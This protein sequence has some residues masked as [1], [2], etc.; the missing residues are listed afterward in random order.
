MFEPGGPN[1]SPQR[2]SGQAQVA[3]CRA[4][5]LDPKYFTRWKG[6]L[7]EAFVAPPRRVPVVVAPSAEPPLLT[8][9]KAWLDNAVHSVL[10]KDSLG[11]PRKITAAPGP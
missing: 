8:R 9:F 3:Y 7:R 4:R 2:K 1:T 6:K 5:G 10:P 11:E